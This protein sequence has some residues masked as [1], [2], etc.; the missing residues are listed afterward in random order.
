[1]MLLMELE[2]F[3]GFVWGKGGRAENQTAIGSAVGHVNL[4]L[5]GLSGFF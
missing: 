3:K 1:M 5:E 2:L 4:L